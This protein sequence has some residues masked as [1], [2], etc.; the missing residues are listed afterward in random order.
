M[1]S[2]DGFYWCFYVKVVCKYN[3]IGGVGL[4]DKRVW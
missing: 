3:T 1:V 4:I 2:A